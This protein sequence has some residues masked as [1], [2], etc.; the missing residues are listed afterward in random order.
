[1]THRPYRPRLYE[2]STRLNTARR[3]HIK[4]F[5][6]FPWRETRSP[7][8]MSEFLGQLH[9]HEIAADPVPPD[10]A[11]STHTRRPGSNSSTRVRPVTPATR[12]ANC[13]EPAPRRATVP[14]DAVPAGENAAIAAVPNR[15]GAGAR[16]PSGLGTPGRYSTRTSGNLN[17]TASAALSHRSVPDAMSERD[18]PSRSPSRHVRHPTSPPASSNTTATYRPVMTAR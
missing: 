7:L 1:M 18:T 13:A 5:H 10:D 9:G 14:D 15:R 4:Q 17:E 11:H 2:G 16:S 6:D 3:R 12:T 8:Q